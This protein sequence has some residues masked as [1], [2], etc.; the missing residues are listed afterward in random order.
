M[1]GDKELA[2]QFQSLMGVKDAL[3]CYDQKPILIGGELLELE[4]VSDEDVVFESGHY[5][6]VS[7]RH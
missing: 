3:L 4:V 7:L 1:P 5:Y 2:K 6:K